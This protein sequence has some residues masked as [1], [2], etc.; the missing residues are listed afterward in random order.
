MKRVYKVLLP[1][2][3]EKE[4]STEL[5]HQWKN[6]AAGLDSMSMTLFTKLL[7]RIT[8]SWCIHI[9]LEE[10]IEFLNKLYDRIIIKKIVRGADGST[11][12]LLPEIFCEIT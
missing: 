11:V 2:Y 12:L 10:Y 6:D 1:L 4:V 5:K 7:F 9:D 3:R 8:H